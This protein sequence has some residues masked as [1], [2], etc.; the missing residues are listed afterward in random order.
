LAPATTMALDAHLPAHGHHRNPIDVG[1]DAT[2]ERYARA[3]V[4]AARDPNTDAVLLLLTP[5]A[6]IDPLKTAEEVSRLAP[7]RDRPILACWRGG[8]AGPACLAVL[9]GAGIPTF[10]GPDA[11]LR[12]LDYLWRHEEIRQGLARSD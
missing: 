11:A 1:D 9:N 10:P 12:A 4:L 7:I 2:S 8:A 5:H 6:T 3:A